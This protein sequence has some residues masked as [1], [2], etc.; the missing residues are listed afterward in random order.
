MRLVKKVG[1]PR[2]YAD[3]MT[4]TIELRVTPAQ[5]LELQ[6]VAAEN[7]DARLQSAARRGR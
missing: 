3:A 6:R 4:V 1:R 5:R 7:R 2:Q